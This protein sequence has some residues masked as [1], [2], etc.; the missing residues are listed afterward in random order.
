LPGA[1]EESRLATILRWEGPRGLLLRALRRALHPLLRVHR[2]FFFETDLAAAPPPPAP[3]GIPLELRVGAREDLVRFA[4]LLARLDISL[5]S[6]LE[7]VAGG[8]L[9]LLA[10]HQ[11]ALVGIQW[12][13]IASS[14]WVD[15]AGVRLRLGPDEACNYQAAT[16][17]EWRGRGVGPALS[18]LAN[19]VERARG[20]R[21]HISW[22]RADNRASLRLAAK[23]GRRRTK[24]VWC[25]W[26]LGMRRP[27]VIGAT[28]EGSP[29]LERP[30]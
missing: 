22:I 26:T 21:R 13:S 17:P 19:E 11:G 18:R 5:E 28:R 24:T 9:P 30:P 4:P 2:V 12:L 8:D 10:L 1:P 6:A 16:L 15:E 20:M 7:Q 23:V 29:R 3:T 25:I 27:L 14:P